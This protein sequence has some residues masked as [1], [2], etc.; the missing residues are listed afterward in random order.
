MVRPGLSPAGASGSMMATACSRDH[1]YRTVEMATILRRNAPLE[2]DI[3]ALIQDGPADFRVNGQVYT[4]RDIFDLEMDRIFGTT[5]VYVAHESEISNPG[6]YRTSYIGRRPVIVSRGD[7]GEIHVLLN[8]CRHRASVVCRNERGTAKE[9]RC[10]YHGWLYANNGDLISLAHHRGAYPDDIDKSTLGLVRV[11]RVEAYRGLIFAS[12]SPTGESLVD[13]LG[14]ARRYIDFQFDRSP[15]GKVDA[16]YGA[17][18]S[19]YQGNWKFQAE[20]TTDGYHGDTVH[21]SFWQLLAEFGHAGGRHG[22]YT[23]KGMRDI[24]K[25]RQTGRTVGFE[26]GHG[27][28]EYPIADEA[29]E[30]M[31]SG[32]HAD[33]MSKLEERH[34]RSGLI[35]IFNQ[36]NVLVFPNLGLLHGQIRIIRPIAIDQTEVSI[37]FYA[38]EGVPDAYNDERQNGYERFFGPASFG[39]PDDV[40][41]LC[42]ESDR[43]SGRRG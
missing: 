22:S 19:E 14:P 33:Y 20:N 16:R 41:D 39:S 9:F 15:V 28:L 10:R 30:A 21:E 7:D 40:R 5:W 42:D 17:H 36:M 13:H 23:Q 8:R 18:R 26:N 4:D 2:I 1:N 38:L 32:P 11:P 43:A 29:V 35:D 24:I 25:H 27:M 31:R 3:D 34:G 6:D 12:M 37:Q